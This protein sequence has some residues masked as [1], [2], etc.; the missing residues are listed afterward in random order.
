MKGGPSVDN[1]KLDCNPQ[2]EPTTEESLRFARAIEALGKHISAHTVT[3]DNMFAKDMTAYRQSM[4]RDTRCPT[5]LDSAPP[6]MA[7]CGAN[8]DWLSHS[9]VRSAYHIRK[10][11]LPG[12]IA[13]VQRE[14]DI[15]LSVG[16][17]PHEAAP[18]LDQMLLKGAPAKIDRPPLTQKKLA[19]DIA[20][21]YH[22]SC[23]RDRS[24]LRKEMR[25]FVKKGFWIVL[26][27]EDD[28]GLD[29]L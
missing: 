6:P 28:V 1:Q 22:N 2:A 23:D 24:F 27:L 25:D 18:L 9:E 19:P 20:Y 5:H 15:H 16:T 8:T 11:G 14:P 7:V 12:M 17:L 29:S 10:L 26:S 4:G 3:N 21:G 13:S